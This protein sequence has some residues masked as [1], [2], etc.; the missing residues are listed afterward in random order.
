VQPGT[1]IEDTP[2]A[3]AIKAKGPATAKGPD[4][5]TLGDALDAAMANLGKPP[6][7]KAPETPPTA[8]APAPPAPEP[9]KPAPAA[10][11]KDFKDIPEGAFT[12]KPKPLAEDIKIDEAV[13]GLSPKAAENFRT[14]EK[15]LRDAETRASRAAELEAEVTKLKGAANGH[16]VEALK[17]QL[18]EAEEALGKTNLAAVPRFRRHYEGGI[19][20]EMVLL[21]Q[22][23][24]D[25]SADVLSLAALPPSKERDTRLADI[26]D[27]LDGINAAKLAGAVDRID[28]LR[29]ERETELSNWRANLDKARQLEDQE[30]TQAQERSSEQLERLFERHLPAFQHPEKGMEIYRTVEG[31]EEWNSEVNG[32]I[33]NAR[34]LLTREFT[35]HD[36]FSMV[37]RAIATDK[38]RELYLLQHQKIAK[39][40]DELVAL[41]GAAPGVG[42]SGDTP[43]APKNEKFGDRIERIG[44]ESGLLK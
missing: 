34:D 17:K 35:P 11:I 36:R 30:S 29:T 15:R 38:Y 18:V 33:E 43:P 22:V 9:P 24:G 42:G 44:R 23:S 8:P 28:R 16:E 21:K 14:L 25:K 13:K 5:K 41:R 6:E 7:A 1:T 12:P 31:N 32:R 20:N 4:G 40:N 39:L 2:I 37:L 27:A 26:A 10:P 19:E 3:Q